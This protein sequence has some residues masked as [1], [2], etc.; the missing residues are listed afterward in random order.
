MASEM[1]FEG[2]SRGVGK[3]LL[4]T[5]KATCKQVTMQ[6]ALDVHSWTGWTEL[7]HKAGLWGSWRRW[8]PGQ[9]SLYAEAGLM[10][11]SE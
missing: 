5:W 1:G 4:G 3:S 9:D 11:A 2:I 6:M 8:L 7:S 10:L